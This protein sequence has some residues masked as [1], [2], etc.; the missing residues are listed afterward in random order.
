MKPEDRARLQIDRL[1][2]EADW[3]IQNIQELN[4]GASMG[5][6]VREVPVKSGTVDYMLFVDRVAVGVIE[7]KPEGTTLIGVAEQSDAYIKAIPDNLPHVQEPL[8]FA[9][10]STGIETNFRDLRDPEPCSRRI[11]A[12]HK[13]ETLKEWISAEQTIRRKLRGMPQLIT[14][15]LRDCQI[16]AIHNLEDSF[17]QAKPRA[18]IQM[19]S[20]GG[21]TFT[22]HGLMPRNPMAESSRRIKKNG[23]T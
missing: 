23:S 13:P 4:L 21:K 20:G 16:E 9:Y 7:A 19:A 3:K 12:F 14:N 18:L 15:R 22:A 11:F 17:E 5:I 8:P 2:E 6:A 1:L 10:E